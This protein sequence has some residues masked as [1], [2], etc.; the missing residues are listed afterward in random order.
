[1]AAAIAVLVA[2]VATALVAVRER[3]EICRLRYQVWDLERRRDALEREMREVRSSIAAALSPRRLLED[4]DR[5][6]IQ[7]SL[8]A[9]PAAEPP[10][11][12]EAP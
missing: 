11:D 2:V 7:A 10:T 8:A 5:G 4:H 9:A 12:E 6:V 1:M 3:T